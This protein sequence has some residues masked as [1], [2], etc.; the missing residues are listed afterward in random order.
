MKPEVRRGTPNDL[1]GVMK[2]FLACWRESYRGILPDSVVDA[3]TDTAARTMWRR[4]LASARGKSLVAELGGKI[5][6][7]T[8]YDTDQNSSERTGAVHSLYT[9]PG[10]QGAGIGSFLLGAAEEAIHSAGLRSAT[11]WV[12]ADNTPS[13]G[14]YTARGWIPD[15][16][17][18]TE[19]QF[20]ALEQRMRKDLR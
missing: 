12:F 3:M 4:A 8:R 15:G 5:A 20:G 17:T 1:A 13:I 16:V 18:R 2:V 10:V 14:F 11:L 19:K 6:G 9:D 7:I